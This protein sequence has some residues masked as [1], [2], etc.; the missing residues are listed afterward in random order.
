VSVANQRLK[1]RRRAAPRESALGAGVLL[2]S[3]GREFTPAAIARAAELA[4]GDNGYVRVFSIARV[5]GVA[6]GLPNP[7]LLPTKREWDEQRGFVDAAVKRLRRKGIEADGHVVGTR[8]ATKFICEEADRLSCD[9]IVM[10]ADASRGRVRG[11]WLWSQE[12]QRVQRKSKLPVFL[13][14]S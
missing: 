3:E 9:A 10:G 6:F 1:R 14:E 12:P 2:A 8:K 11:D 5:H 7:G 13:V 4:A